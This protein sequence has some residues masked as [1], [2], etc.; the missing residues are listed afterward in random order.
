MAKAEEEG[1]REARAHLHGILPDAPLST[2]LLSLSTL[3]LYLYPVIHSSTEEVSGAQPPSSGLHQREMA[4][5]SGTEQTSP[6]D[7][8]V[9]VF[10]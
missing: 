9:S 2:L 1:V 10:D 7:W 4:P 3:P 8:R 6:R 5:R